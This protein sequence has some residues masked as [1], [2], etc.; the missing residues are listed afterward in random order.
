MTTLFQDYEGEITTI[1][2]CTCQQLL[3][4][5]ARAD[6]NSKSPCLF[7]LKIQNG[8]WHRF[9]IDINL[10]YMRWEQ[11]DELDESDWENENLVDIGIQ[12]HLLGLQIVKAEMKQ[13][14]NAPEQAGRFE[15]VFSDGRMLIHTVNEHEQ[16][17]ELHPQ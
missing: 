16:T 17:L 7:W 14:G 13:I 6:D 5:Y 4:V 11:E 8:C 12:Y 15:L 3:C 10:Y 2:G 9:F 1:I